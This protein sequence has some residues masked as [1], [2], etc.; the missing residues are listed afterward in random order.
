M[1][2]YSEQN[3]QD[4]LKFFTRIKS[5]YDGF[6]EEH[7]GLIFLLIAAAV[8]DCLS[9]IYFMHEVGPAKELNPVIRYLGYN[10]GPLYGPIL[11]KYLQI[12]VGM[13]AVIYFRNLAKHILVITACLY[14]WA[15]C[16]NFIAFMGIFF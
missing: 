3:K 8:V 12:S 9:T 14:S 15:A 13:I 4:I 1:E 2:I 11:G 10:L 7:K 6:Y 5:N 16:A